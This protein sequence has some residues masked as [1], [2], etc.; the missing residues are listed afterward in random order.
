VISYIRRNLVA[1]VALFVAIIMTGGGV[2]YA[3]NTVRSSDIVDGQ[4]KNQD[5]APNS[6]GNGKIQDGS[7]LGADIKDGSLTGADINKSTLG[8]VPDANALQGASLGSI[9][10]LVR[11]T[12]KTA[13]DQTFQCVTP[14]VWSECGKI[15]LDVP[16][17]HTY[18]VTIWS[19]VTAASAT[20]SQNVFSCPA[21]TGP[22]CVDGRAEYPR[23]VTGIETNVASSATVNLGGGHY[24][25]STAVLFQLP[26]LNEQNNNAITT[27]EYYDAGA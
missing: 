15:P 20:G 10:D 2:A 23:F 22:T 17:G 7:V 18:T 19:S 1:F 6:V 3:A 27:V 21:T 14:G 9:L 13:A 25:L 11:H 4:V 24:E 5:L 12:T 16:A 8:R 26:I